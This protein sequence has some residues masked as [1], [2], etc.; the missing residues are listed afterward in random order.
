MPRSTP[1][2]QIQLTPE[3]VKFL[4]KLSHSYSASF[5]EVQ[6]AR[7]LLLAHQSHSNAEIARRVGCSDQRVRNWRRRFSKKQSITDAD[8]SGHPR[9]LTATH[10]ASMAALACSSPRDHHNPWQR[11]SGE[12]LEQVALGAIPERVVTDAHRVLRARGNRAPP[13]SAGG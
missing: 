2:Y 3:Q 9:R 13:I 1:K 4:T 11:W 12:K 10:R 6:R 5:A 8:R 7:I